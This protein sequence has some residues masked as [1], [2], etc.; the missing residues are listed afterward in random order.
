MGWGI[1]QNKQLIC[2]PEY[3]RVEYLIEIRALIKLK[4][5]TKKHMQHIR[6]RLGNVAQIKF[7]GKAFLRRLDACIYLPKFNDNDIINISQF[8]L[9]D[10]IWWEFVLSDPKLV[11]VPFDF[12]LKSPDD[13][14]LK[15]YT[16]ATTKIGFAA[17]M[18][19]LAF[20]VKFSDTIINQVEKMRGPLDIALFELLAPVVAC[21]VFV[22]EL[23][24]KS[25][26]MYIDNPGAASAV[27][28]KAPR[29]YRLDMNFLI[30]YLAKLAIE[31]N[32]M[33]WGIHCFDARM[34]VADGLSRYKTEP[35]YNINKN[36]K[37]YNEK[38]LIITNKILTQ[39]MLYPNNLNDNCDIPRN[40]RAEFNILLDEKCYKFEKQRKL[41]KLNNLLKY[42]TLE[43]RSK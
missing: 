4:K 26:S 15:L 12:I 8:V 21:E 37:S 35:K 32:F 19:N 7:P 33:F 39:L 36:F 24:G 25:V 14:D 16:D 42:N 30:L 22:S 17:H 38:A 23:T 20:Q 41:D 34:D 2:L 1:K 28:T 5:C 10:L 18:N 3:K 43:I 31:F 6:G 29:L 13:A 27:A 9:F 11:E 40:I